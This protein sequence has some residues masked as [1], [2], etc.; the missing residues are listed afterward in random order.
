MISAEV[1]TVGRTSLHV[2]CEA[3]HSATAAVLI[4]KGASKEARD[5]SGRTPLHLAAVHRHTELVQ[6]LLDAECQ[7][8]AV[9]NNGVTALQMA[10]AQGCRG[11]VEHLLAFGA[12]VHLQNNVGSSALHAACAADANDIVELLLAHGADPAMTDQWAQSPVSV[13][14]GGATE[15]PPEGFRRAARGSFSAILDLIT[16]TTNLDIHQEQHWH[17]SQ[18]F[19][20]HTFRP[21]HYPARLRRALTISPADTRLQLMKGLNTIAHGD[22][23][24]AHSSIGW[25]REA[26]Q[27]IQDLLYHP[28][29]APVTASCATAQHR[30]THPRMPRRAPATAPTA[31][32]AAS[33]RLRT[34]LPRPETRPPCDLPPH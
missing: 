27:R 22:G 17:S 14:G 21:I 12:N 8:D 6:V 25:H 11:I 1:G 26:S 23:Q 4:V 20:L 30:R 29:A 34:P 18:N 32:H 19:R 31:P 9:D 13:A 5:N 3:G 16:A 10:C 7:V 2:T 15:S 28:R 24:R 33:L